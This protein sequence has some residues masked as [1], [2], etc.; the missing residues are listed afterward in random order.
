[1]HQSTTTW[2]AVVEISARHDGGER[3]PR[4]EC[5]Q[6]LGSSHRIEAGWKSTSPIQVNLFANSTCNPIFENCLDGRK[7]RSADDRD[8][9]TVAA[10]CWKMVRTLRRFDLDDVADFQ[11][12]V[13]VVSNNDPILNPS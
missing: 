8:Q 11:A 6:P 5:N 7:T 4:E 12:F 10:F 3:R 13:H 1:M 2:P 9:G